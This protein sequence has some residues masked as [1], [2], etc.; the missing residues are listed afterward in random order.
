MYTILSIENTVNINLK[1]GDI[2]VCFYMWCNSL[3]CFILWSSYLG[4]IIYN[5]NKAMELFNP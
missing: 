5:K 2:N 3:L 1:D 4:L